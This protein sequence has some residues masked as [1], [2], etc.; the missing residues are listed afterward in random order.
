[1]GPW[2]RFRPRRVGVVMRR[3]AVLAGAGAV[4]A[5]LLTGCGAGAD[6]SSLTVVYEKSGEQQ[7]VVFTP[8]QVTCHDD[9][10]HGVSV[11][12]KPQGQFTVALGGDRRLRVGAASDEGLVLFD[13]TGGALTVEGDSLVVGETSGEV[14]LVAGWTPE[15]GTDVDPGDAERF[16]ATVSGRIHCD[17][18]P[19][20]P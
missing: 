15:D 3:L 11:Q 9:L 5:S 19:T 18:V 13:A 10:V 6:A 16:E 8:D 14:A 1:M 17:H 7:R 20:L 12:A 2:R 4:L